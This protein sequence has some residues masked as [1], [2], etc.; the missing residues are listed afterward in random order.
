MILIT[1][2]D[3]PQDLILCI[4]GRGSRDDAYTRSTHVCISHFLFVRYGW[5]LISN[6]F[7]NSK[8]VIGGMSSNITFSIMENME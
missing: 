1:E 8:S 7:Y 5:N 4:K 3:E 2:S 6:L